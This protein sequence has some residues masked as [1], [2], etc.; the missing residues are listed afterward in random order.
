VKRSFIDEITAKARVAV[1][2]CAHSIAPSDIAFRKYKRAALLP[3]GSAQMSGG[4]R[5]EA[6][7]GLAHKWDTAH[8]ALLLAMLGGVV[9]RS[10]Q[11]SHAAAMLSASG[12]LSENGW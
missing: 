2:A 8:G 1:G 7:P 12:D 3:F 6:L 10:Q 5:I 9:I 11:L 4:G